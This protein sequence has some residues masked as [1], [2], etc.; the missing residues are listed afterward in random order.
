[1]NK[2]FKL[3]SK[4]IYIC[5]VSLIDLNLTDLNL[6]IQNQR[7]HQKKKYVILLKTIQ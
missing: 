2:K 1:M 4:Q 6:V 3:F 7:D 5:F